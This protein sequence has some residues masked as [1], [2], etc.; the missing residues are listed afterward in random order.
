MTVRN[1]IV[2]GYETDCERERESAREFEKG[3][4]IEM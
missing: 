2:S 4:W 1:I 3:G